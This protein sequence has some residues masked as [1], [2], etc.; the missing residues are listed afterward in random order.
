M[1]LV[2]SPEV[3][4]YIGQKARFIIILLLVRTWIVIELLSKM[5]HFQ[6]RTFPLYLEI[7][8]FKALI[9]KL[10]GK[11]QPIYIPSDNL[12]IDEFIAHF[13]T[14]QLLSVYTWKKAQIHM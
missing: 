6:I 13:M 11:Y 3:F 14:C 5:M 1:G 7:L 12:I 10:L 8:K 4:F 2:P 9:D